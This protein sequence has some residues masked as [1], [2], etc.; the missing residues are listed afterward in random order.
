MTAI[1]DFDI[2]RRSIPGYEK[3]AGQLKMASAVQKA[4]E[5]KEHLVVEA[6]CGVGKSFA[7]LVP[8]I[9]HALATQT[10]V[11]VVTANIALQEQLV[12]KD[13]PILART[14]PDRFTFALIKG[15]NNYLCLDR[16]EAAK[17][18]YSQLLLQPSESEEWERLREWADRTP[19]GDP[20]E[21]D[22]S[23]D[24]VLWNKVNGVND[25]CNGRKCPK[26]D[27]CFAMAARRQLTDADVIV[28]NYH[29]YFA[30]L[31]VRMA[32]ERDIILPTHSAVVCDEAHEMADI[33][34]DFLG[35][36]LTVHSA[37]VL[38]AGAH[39][40]GL[41]GPADRVRSASNEFF[42]EV[43]RHRQSPAYKVRLKTPDFADGRR[44]AE[45]VEAY[46]Q[47]AVG[48]IG[49]ARNE[50]EKDHLVKAAGACERYVETLDA[51]RE[52][53][54]SNMVYYIDPDGRLV[55]RL[56]DVSGVLRAELFEEIDTVVMTSA[57]MAT[58]SSFGF[59]KRETGC[60]GARELVVPSPFDFKKQALLVVPEME[61][62][63]N[64]AGFAGEVA[65]HLKRIIAF[66]GGRTLALFT[67]YR[68]LEH[69]AQAA[70]ET[71]VAILKQGDR[72]RGKLLK[73]FREDRG[74]ALFATSSFWQGVD[75]PGEALSVLTIDKIP[76]VTPEDPL[77][78]ALQE[79]DPQTFTNYQV[80][81]ATLALRQG[82][83]RLIRTAKDR[84]V[85]V[86]FDR[87][88]FKM[89]Y[90]RE[91]LKALPAAPVKR[92]LDALEAFFAKRGRGR[93]GGAS[94]QSDGA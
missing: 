30:H 25:L 92:D 77:L 47:E 90:G 91:M 9:R 5:D 60:D 57:T 35:R 89:R 51:F 85:V 49:S 56:I 12:E 93:S 94:I 67:S 40:L 84:G 82:F 74:T 48:R 14:L 69:C 71:G 8:A 75:V 28:T 83:G 16:Y 59:H 18:D 32:A 80:P 7:Y 73:E 19:T 1:A 27:A 78:D 22:A 20:S 4:L 65:E 13:L 81:K 54:D 15:L 39:R 44:L 62:G 36:R 64:D 38:L 58:G 70:R 46:R 72:P 23:L 68:V 63:P 79:R 52:M 31:N 37:N 11:V 45:S 29:L 34:R 33:A 3:R 50:D 53:D 43:R 6:P 86:I 66:L 76:F 24:P 42:E 2:L 41:R 21:L 87:R 26:F 17:A 55:S 61:A 88:L 10:R